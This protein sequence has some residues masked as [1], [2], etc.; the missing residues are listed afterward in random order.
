MDA[1]KVFEEFRG[2]PLKEEVFMYF[3]IHKKGKLNEIIDSIKKINN[4]ANEKGIK[5]ILDYFVKIRFLELH[6]KEF[7]VVPGFLTDIEM[8]AELL[9]L[10]NSGK[11]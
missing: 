7:V 4:K 1:G 2:N 6:G 5:E 3:V 10:K 9:K 8:Q 11:I